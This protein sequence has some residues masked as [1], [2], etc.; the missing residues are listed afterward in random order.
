MQELGKLLLL[1]DRLTVKGR[2]ATPNGEVTVTG[3]IASPAV[4]LMGEMMP[5]PLASVTFKVFC[6]VTV[7]CAV[8]LKTN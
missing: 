7:I 1:P 6:G 3:M 8:R 2:L 5:E 4:L